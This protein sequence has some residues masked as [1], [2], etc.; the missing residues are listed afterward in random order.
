M[1]GN[2][3]CYCLITFSA[4]VVLCPGVD[5]AS[6]NEYQNISVGK[7]GRCLRVTTLPPSKCRTSW[8]SGALIYRIPQ[9][10]VETCSGRALPL[11]MFFGINSYETVFGLSCF[12]LQNIWS[13]NGDT[14]QTW[15]QN[16]NSVRSPIHTYDCFAAY[17]I[18][19]HSVSYCFKFLGWISSTFVK[20][21]WL[22]SVSSGK[23]RVV[24]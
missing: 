4:H 17:R 20:F 12:I 6:K 13:Q 16:E 14:G 21:S 24:I 9:G 23:S 5:S 1:W 18:S 7:D 19:R 15:S 2:H 11:H 8:K 22:P 10:P 3:V